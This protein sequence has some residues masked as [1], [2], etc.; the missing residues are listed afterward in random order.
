MEVV[1]LSREPRMRQGDDLE[2]EVAGLHIR[3]LVSFALECL[4]ESSRREKKRDREGSAIN[5]QGGHGEGD[6]MASPSCMPR[7]MTI[8]SRSSAT[9]TFVPPQWGHTLF[10]I[11]PRPPH[12]SHLLLVGQSNKRERKRKREI[13]E[14]NRWNESERERERE[15]RQRH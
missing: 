13:V 4:T 14:C 15:H 1:A 11:L 6:T 7:S 12:S 10:A 9:S 3:L 2:D 8:V 5:S